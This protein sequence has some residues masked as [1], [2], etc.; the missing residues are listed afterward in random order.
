MFEAI[1]VYNEIWEGWGYNKEILSQTN[2]QKTIAS[3]SEGFLQSP[4]S[5]SHSLHQLRGWISYSDHLRPQS[6]PSPTHHKKDSKLC[7]SQSFL[8]S[9]HILVMPQ[10]KVSDTAGDSPLLQAARGR[11]SHKM[12]PLTHRNLASKLV[13]WH[14]SVVPA[15]C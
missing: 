11:D 1:L 7:I 12:Y 15:Q 2:K 13:W 4:L 6:P 10:S 14:M 8:S 5:A 3:S 9:A